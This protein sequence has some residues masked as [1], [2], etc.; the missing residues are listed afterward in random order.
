LAVTPRTNNTKATRVTWK[1]MFYIE[2]ASR[3][4][5]RND[6]IFFR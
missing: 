6:L 4:E 1:C 2:K 5:G 3:Q